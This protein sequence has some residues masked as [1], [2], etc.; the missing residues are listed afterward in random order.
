MTLHANVI[1]ILDMGQAD[2]RD[3]LVMDY[4]DG[5]LRRR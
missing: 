1:R 2:G 4:V 3:Y 5:A